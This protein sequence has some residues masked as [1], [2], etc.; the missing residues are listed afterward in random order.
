[1]FDSSKHFHP[2]P[3]FVTYLYITIYVLKSNCL[4]NV[5]LLCPTCARFRAL[6]WFPNKHIVSDVLT[7]ESFI[8]CLPQ[9]AF[10]S[11]GEIAGFLAMPTH[12]GLYHKTHY[13][14]N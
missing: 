10:A 11:T 4:E 14:R 13:G 7:T 3:Q 1:M 6:Q 9:E 2:S 8:G 12:W 5:K